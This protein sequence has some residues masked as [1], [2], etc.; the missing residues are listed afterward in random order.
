MDKEREETT[1]QPKTIVENSSYSS[2]AHAEEWSFY[3]IKEIDYNDRES[4]TFLYS[5]PIYTSDYGRDDS[6]LIN[7]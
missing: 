1:E 2:F 6:F 4:E 3:I 7:F 5:P